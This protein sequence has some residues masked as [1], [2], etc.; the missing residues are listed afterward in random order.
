MSAATANQGLEVGQGVRPSAPSR[1]G[2]ILRNVCKD[3]G[4]GPVLRNVD[5]TIENGEF[6][7]LLGPSG[8]GKST[9]LS[10]VAGF[11]EF[12]TGEISLDSRSLVRVPPHKRGI[13]LVFQNYSLFPHMRVL[14]NV[15][16]P[17]RARGVEER[18]MRAK[19]ESALELVG[20]GAFSNRYPGELSGGQQQRAALARAIVFEPDLLL[21]DEPMGALDRRLRVKMQVEVRKLQR[22]LGLTVLYVTHDQEEALSMADKV[23][24]LS[25]G[26][27][28]Q[29]GTPREVY[30]RP[31]NRFV[32]DFLGDSNLLAGTVV[33]DDEATG[34]LAVEIAGGVR[35]ECPRRPDLGVGQE[36]EIVIRPE[37][38]T[39]VRETPSGAGP[40]L[41]R[42]ELRGTVTELVYLGPSVKCW[43]TLESGTEVVALASGYDFGTERL[44]I[45]SQVR[46]TYRPADIHVL[47]GR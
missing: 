26:V 44:G 2:L 10:L 46:L 40:V 29:V 16:F 25:E 27:L 34:C 18:E 31:A 12:D 39:L 28:V 36:A 42:H 3:Y 17:L 19:A 38:L 13:G 9:I 33:G 5:L 8:S 6:L 7:T 35:I 21:M 37:A 11:T 22:R 14:D 24:V 23:G 1:E 20:M 45:G 30:E 4:H 15:C 41:D 32:A 43:L 47:P